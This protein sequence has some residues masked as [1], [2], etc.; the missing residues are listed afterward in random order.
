MDSITKAGNTSVSKAPS[1]YAGTDG[2]YARY[3]L[4]LLFLV[5]VLLQMDRNIVSILAEDVKKSFELSD[6]QLGFLGGTSFAVFYALFGY[7][8]ARLADRWSRVKLLTIGLALWSL[9]TIMCGRATSFVEMSIYRMGVGIGESTGGPVGHSL[10]ADWFSKRKRATA[11]GLISAGLTIGA[12]LSLLLGGLIVSRWNL[13]FPDAKPLGLEGWRITF[14]I[15]GVLGL[16]VAIWLSTLRDPIR[17]QSEGIVVPAVDRI[18]SRFFRDLCGILPPLTLY[19]AARRGTTAF[20]INI[21]AATLSF[22]AAWCLIWLTGD[23][24]QWTAIGI[25][26]YAAFSAMQSLRH[27]DRPAFM[28]TWETPAFLFAVLGFGATS[29]VSHITAFWTAPL[30]LRK[31]DIDRETVGLILGTASALGG[32][33]GM[34]IGGRLSDILLRRTAR[35]RIWVAM[36]SVLIPLPLI[37]VMCLTPDPTIFF[38]CFIPVSL[39]STGWVA[40][41]AATIQD[42]V[43]PRVRG[44][45]ANLYFLVATLVGTG[46]GPYAVGKI[47]V[48][49]GS[50]PIALI[51]TLTVV[52]LAAGIFLWLCGRK[53]EEAEA[54][55][56]V[57]AADAMQRFQSP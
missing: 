27:Y 55:K 13:A 34:I 16:G 11:L 39:I 28:L 47:S 31:F 1:S 40:C 8:I 53:I 9:M 12:G 23:W 51:S 54:T 17:G 48:T 46:L 30:A 15:F 32:A 4:C 22:L 25:G 50:L 18:W 14:M 38:T 44:T 10:V 29:M 6:S 49:T 7:P 56:E 37:I 42:L 57:R 2:P 20:M 21:A 43:V 3:V 41:G 5:Y 45:A 36:G 24:L 19:D 52:I 26:Y 33:A 35:G